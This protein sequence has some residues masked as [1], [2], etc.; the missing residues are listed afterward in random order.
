M[1][2]SKNHKNYLRYR[3]AAP[4]RA[5]AVCSD[6]HSTIYVV[7]GALRQHRNLVR[8][9][10]SLGPALQSPQSRERA[11][12][13]LRARISSV[14]YSPSLPAAIPRMRG[15]S[16]SGHITPHHARTPPRGHGRRGLPT[17]RRGPCSLDERCAQ[18]DGA[19]PPRGVHTQYFSNSLVT[20]AMVLPLVS[21]SL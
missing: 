3:A 1:I 19:M 6:V 2:I 9:R 18:L 13:P 5:H 11:L 21:G 10:P 14:A 20:W 16:V 17:S 4:P 8:P 12:L 15:M 7:R